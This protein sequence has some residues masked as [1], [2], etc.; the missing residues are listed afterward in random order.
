MF[1]VTADRAVVVDIS[2]L[3]QG[4]LFDSLFAQLA[5]ALDDRLAEQVAVGYLSPQH[6]YEVEAVATIRLK[7]ESDEPMNLELNLPDD[8]VLLSGG[9]NTCSVRIDQI[10]ALIERLQRLYRDTDPEDYSHWIDVRRLLWSV[11]E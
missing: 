11:R 8:T 5:S 4:P 2:E 10:P 9:G 1:L 6:T 7:Y 3:L